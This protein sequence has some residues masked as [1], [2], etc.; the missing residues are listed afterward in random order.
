MAASTNDQTSLSEHADPPQ[1][2]NTA[3]MAQL[4][5][6]TEIMDAMRDDLNT[7]TA[8]VQVLKRT[9]RPVATQQTT[10]PQ[11]T[12]TTQHSTQ[13]STLPAPHEAPKEEANSE[14]NAEITAEKQAPVYQAT[15]EDD[16][17]CTTKHGNS[18]LT[19]K[20]TLSTIPR[21]C[22]IPA[23]RDPAACLSNAFFTHQHALNPAYQH[24]LILG[25]MLNT[26]FGY[27]EHSE[28]MEATGQG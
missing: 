4:M 6:I 10:A 20:S 13:Q 11:T 18:M 19:T 14:E 1:P 16:M 7:V 8:G 25:L 22:T 2:D 28:S 21:L 27:I 3:I 23:S 5:Q 24:A 9:F 17:E 26:R 15:V 12:Q